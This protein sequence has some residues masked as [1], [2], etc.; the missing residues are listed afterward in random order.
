MKPKG[1][2]SNA[3][4]DET[5]ELQGFK[6]PKS[7]AESDDGAESTKTD[8]N[9]DDESIQTHPDTDAEIGMGDEIDEDD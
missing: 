8:P 6:D 4:V 3:F 9:T 5:K 2:K 7:T 1:F